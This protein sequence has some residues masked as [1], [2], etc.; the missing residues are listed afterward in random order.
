MG[1]R[2]GVNMGWAVNR[3]PEPEV[4]TR[5]V[6]EEL[7]LGYVQ[8]VAD[9]INPFWPE[10]YVDDQVRRI[11]AA[12]EKHDI[13]VESIMTSTF[14]RVNHLMSPDERA[15]EFWLEWFKKLL[16]IGSRLGVRSGGSHFGIMTFDTYGDPAK[17]RSA[18]SAAVEG[19]QQLTYEAERLGMSELIF[20]PMSV[21]REMANTVE[22]TR[23]LLGLVN[24][25][26]GVPLRVCLDV[27]HAPHPSQRD[28]YPWIVALAAD[29][30]C[31]HLQQTVLNA[32]RHAPFTAEHNATGIIEPHKVMRAVAQ[33]GATDALFAFEIVHREHW[34]TDSRVVQDLRE[35]VEYWRPT[36]PDAGG[37]PT[38]VT[39]PEDAC[40]T[41]A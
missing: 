9:L 33:S 37:S 23:E 7:G 18:L 14:T 4:W 10:D 35:S 27:G 36:V 40:E 2:L 19:W 6:R 20:E 16:R 39:R 30:P 21:P 11:G 5:I 25:D 41:V 26:A 22:E 1:F 13:V 38:R 15:R 32:S 17:R 28:P 12:C 29:S 3:Y 31:I 34:D 24:E 8:L